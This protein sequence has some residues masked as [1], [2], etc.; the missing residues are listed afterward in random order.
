MFGSYRA[1]EAELIASF[2]DPKLTVWSETTWKRDIPDVTFRFGPI[3]GT[4]AVGS[5]GQYLVVIPKAGLVAVRLKAIR[6][7]EDVKDETRHFTDFPERVVALLRPAP[8]VGA[9]APSQ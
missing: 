7:T 1:L 2:E 5:Y 6:N 8:L 3:V 4:Y 9:A